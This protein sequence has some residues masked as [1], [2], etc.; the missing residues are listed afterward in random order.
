MNNI[1]LLDNYFEIYF[2]KKTTEFEYKPGKEISLIAFP[3]A[4]GIKTHGLRYELNNDE[5]KFGSKEGA[6]NEAIAKTIRITFK[7]GEILIFKRHFGNLG[8]DQLFL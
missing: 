8:F 5:L 7:S 6:L 1:K 4:T 3:K 2:L